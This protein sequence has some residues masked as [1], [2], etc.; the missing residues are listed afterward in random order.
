MRHL[1]KIRIPTEIGN[2]GVKEGIIPRLVGQ[3]M[4]NFKPEAAY[5]ATENGERTAYFF[6]DLSDSSQMPVLAEPWFM[7]LNARIDMQPVMNG[8]DLQ[9]GLMAL[10]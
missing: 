8:E 10:K 4:E 1:V 9:R 5:F 3:T 6:V 7:E 2:R